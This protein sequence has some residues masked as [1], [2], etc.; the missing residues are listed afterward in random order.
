M[1][2]AASE[3]MPKRGS[4]IGGYVRDDETV[5]KGKKAPAVL[6]EPAKPIKSGDLF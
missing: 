2:Q 4:L 3:N 5:R 6:G 1:S